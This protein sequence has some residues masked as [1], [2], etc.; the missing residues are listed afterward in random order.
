M[1]ALVPSARLASSVR[2]L[3]SHAG[4]LTSSRTR[5]EDAA[6]PRRRA[7]WIRVFF[8]RAPETAERGESSDV[9]HFAHHPHL[10][11]VGV[12]TVEGPAFPGCG[13]ELE[14]HLAHVRGG[15]NRF[16]STRGPR[17]RSVHAGALGGV[18]CSCSASGS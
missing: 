11:V 12:V 3:A 10:H 13:P 9:A 5:F 8:M 17:G 1:V 4:A 2:E 14:R 6:A 7:F 16:P 18:P 15:T